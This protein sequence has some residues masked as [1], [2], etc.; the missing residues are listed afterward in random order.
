MGTIKCGFWTTR[1][2]IAPVEFECWINLWQQDGFAWHA[3]NLPE[4]IKSLYEQFYQRR[5]DKLIEHKNIPLICHAAT[6]SGV[7][8]SFRLVSKELS[9]YPKDK[10]VT[11]SRIFLE[12]STPKQYAVAAEDKRYFTYEDILER[13]PQAYELF[14]RYH[15]EIMKITKPL[16]YMERAAYSVRVSKQA[17]SDLCESAFF[18][19]T[20]LGLSSKW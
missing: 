6:K 13:E 1:F 2:L 4:D 11:R 19:H 18:K 14:Q 16:Y 9:F 3:Q 7:Q 5:T 10:N 8:T 12:F 15:A 20:G 17:Y